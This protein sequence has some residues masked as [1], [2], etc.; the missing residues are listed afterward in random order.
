VRIFKRTNVIYLDNHATTPM[1][2][3]VLREMLPYFV[4]RFANA[5]S[6]THSL[7][8]DADEKVEQARAEVARLI[9]ADAREIVFTSGATESNNLSIKGVPEA[10]QKKGRHIITTVIEHKSVLDPCK[11]LSMSGCEVT[12]LPVRSDGIVDVED[13]E[14]AIRPTTILISVMFANNEVGTIQPIAEIGKIA[15]EKGIL[16][17]CDAAQAAGKVPV[18]VKEMGIDLLSFTAHK[19]YGPKGVGA[20]YVRK[21]DPRV[22]LIPIFDGGGHETGLRSG[23]L[24]VPGI[25]AFAK[26]CELCRTGMKEESERIGKLRDRLR[27]KLLKE[28]PGCVVNGNERHH[29][30]HNLNVSF[31]GISAK[32]LMEELPRLALSSGSACTSASLEVSYV[33]KAMGVTEELRRSSIRFGLGRFNNLPEID[34]AALLVARAVQKLR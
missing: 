31:P 9:H 27:D 29:L 11:R 12:Y 18:N 1:D 2:S 6:F 10:Y 17:H 16:F 21:K 3:R 20:L 24:N 5:A 23:T 14:K 28:I 25:V 19:I 26:A 32:K 4:H 22:H 33:L 7:G 30:S 8:R 34:Q 13:L 15:K